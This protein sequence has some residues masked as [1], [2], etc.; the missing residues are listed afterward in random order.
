MK[1]KKGEKVFRDLC[2]NLSKEISGIKL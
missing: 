2:K 1:G